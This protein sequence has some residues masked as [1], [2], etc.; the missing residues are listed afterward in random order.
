MLLKSC[1]ENIET[2]MQSKN[3]DIVRKW[4][5]MALEA[6]LEVDYLKT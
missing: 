3:I 4:H 2:I 6:P 5:T 1:I